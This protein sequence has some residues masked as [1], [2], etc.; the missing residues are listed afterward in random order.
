M[1]AKLCEIFVPIPGKNI[2]LVQELPRLDLQSDFTKEMA[3]R[4][5]LYFI[6]TNSVQG[7]L[8]FA[9]NREVR[10]DY[11]SVFNKEDVLEHILPQLLFRTVN[12]E[13]DEV[14][15]PDDVHH[16]FS[17]SYKNSIGVKAQKR[18]LRSS[19]LE[20]RDRMPRKER[21]TVSQKICEQIWDLILEKDLRVV[22]S[23]LTMG[24]EVNIIPLLQ[25]ALDNNIRVVVPKT[26]RKRQ[27]QNL[28]LTDLKNMEAG[29]FNTYHPKDANEHTGSYDLIIV[30]G[31][32]FDKRG[33]RVGYGG[34]YYDTFLADQGT[35]LKIGV[36]YPFQL[37]ERVPIEGHDI[38]LDQV[39]Y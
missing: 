26:L 18:H 12:L 6:N 27:V 8:C 14:R 38:K 2:Y 32:A 19:L 17:K 37:L 9:E 22:H 3:E 35:A 15:L 39:I 13:Q 11:K 10:S 31:L 16:F 1:K 25:K 7:N 36:C 23:F 21:N 24:S 4:L 20:Q 30:A 28:I 33:F 34:G 29:I 5:G